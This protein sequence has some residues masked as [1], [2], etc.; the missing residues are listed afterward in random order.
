MWGE[1]E[2]GI[3][4]LKEVHDVGDGEILINDGGMGDDLG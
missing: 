3:Y 2:R 1:T 4:T